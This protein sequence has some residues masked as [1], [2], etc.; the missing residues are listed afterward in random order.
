MGSSS[1]LSLPPA[2]AGSLQNRQPTTMW[3]LQV[4]TLCIS[5]SVTMN[6]DI[7]IN[8]H[9]FEIISV[10]LALAGNNLLDF[11]T[12]SSGPVSYRSE[13]DGAS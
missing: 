12:G 11:V 13:R 6:I 2:N 3:A 9:S 5:V 4:S 8:I 7:N 1:P 10:L